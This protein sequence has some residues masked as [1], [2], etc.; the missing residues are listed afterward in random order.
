MTVCATCNGGPQNDGW[1]R[2]TVGVTC[3]GGIQFGRI[4]HC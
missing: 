4:G 3:N 2:M 1:L